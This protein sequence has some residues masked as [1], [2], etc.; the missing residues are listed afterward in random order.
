MVMLLITR[1]A[2]ERL[3]LSIDLRIPIRAGGNTVLA[4]RGLY[5]VHLGNESEGSQ[6]LLLT[7]PSRDRDKLIKRKPCGPRAH[8]SQDIRCPPCQSAIAL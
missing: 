6:V 3:N 4:R 1:H 2:S 8:D 5:E 7:P